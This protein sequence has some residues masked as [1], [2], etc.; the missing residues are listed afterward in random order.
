[1]GRIYRR[2]K[3]GSY[4]GDYATP[5]GKRVQRSLR[6]TD[7]AVARERLRQAELAAT[8]KAR[9]RKQTLS[10]AIDHVIGL[11]HDKAEGTRDM[12]RVKGRRLFATMGDPFVHEITRDTVSDYIK[13]RL[14]DEPYHGGAAPHTVQK[15]LITLRRAL[16]EAH[17][18]G[19]LVVMPSLPRFSPKYKPRETWLTPEQ[20]SNADF[21][22]VMVGADASSTQALG[23]P[24][25]VGDVIEVRD[26][27]SRFSASIKGPLA[28]AQAFTDGARD[29]VLLGPVP[30]NPSDAGSSVAIGLT[31]A[32]TE[33]VAASPLRWSALTGRVLAMGATRELQPIPLPE[34]GDGSPSALS[35]LVIGLVVTAAILVALLVW[36]RKRPHAPPPP[37]PGSPSPA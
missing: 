22:G 7:K 10:D 31:T 28:L 2:H 11:M 14:S 8:P 27:T 1:M 4:Y 36:S 25:A 33:E 34:P 16:L 29:V 32:F 6:T 18:R 35:L 5:E 26:Q 23:A 15:E 21:A 30:S 9:G 17:D 20:F 19:V 12:Y 3:D 13:R 37:L 24:Y